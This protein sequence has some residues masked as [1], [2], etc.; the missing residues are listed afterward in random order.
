MKFKFLKAAIAGLV[1]SVSV[2][3]NAGLILTADG[4]FDTFTTDSGT[5]FL[6]FKYT[7]GKTLSD[8]RTETDSGPLT[9]WRYAN[10]DEAV[11]LLISA[12]PV[13]SSSF[14]YYESLAC[15]GGTAFCPVDESY[16]AR[17]FNSAYD[18]TDPFLHLEYLSKIEVDNFFDVTGSSPTTEH[19]EFR[20]FHAIFGETYT[21]FDPLWDLTDAVTVRIGS[22]GFTDATVFQDDPGLSTIFDTVGAYYHGVGSFVV[23]PYDNYA[24]H[25]LVKEDA[26]SVDEP[27]T[28]WLFLGVILSIAIYK[29]K[30]TNK[31]FKSNS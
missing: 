22:F 8:V 31:V 1:L 28:L 11:D 20:Q 19:N 23:G 12:F 6:S 29:R 25:L 21:Y 26:I 24:E 4:G 10:F 15:L 2:S 5:E 9:G 13:L 30:N 7:S 14:G 16:L 27:N 17:S 3:T 18:I